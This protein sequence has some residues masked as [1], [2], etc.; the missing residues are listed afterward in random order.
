M[1]KHFLLLSFFLFLGTI[2]AQ[3]CSITSLDVKRTTNQPDN[4]M[5][6][7]DGATYLGSA[8]IN[9]AFTVESTAQAF[10]WTWYDINVS[11]VVYTLNST[12]SEANH[13]FDRRGSFWVVVE[14]MD[15]G[16]ENVKDS[17]Q[18]TVS[19]SS[20][21]IP[22][23]F[24]PDGNGQNDRFCVTYQSIVKYQCYIYNRW[25]RLVFSTNR[26]DVCWDGTIG[27]KD[28]DIGAYYYVIEAEGA[29]GVRH[30]KGGDINLVRKSR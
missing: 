12:T 23:L 15:D 7:T 19:D 11:D 25:G 30:K 10:L 4:E 1:K 24:S 14:A 21:R 20:L 22:N 13:T 3:E 6:D 27:G 16:C 2:A 18:I 29:D 17:I 8:P 28:A 9:A 5:P 26:P